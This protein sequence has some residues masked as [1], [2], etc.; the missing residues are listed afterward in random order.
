M[1]LSPLHDRLHA[2]LAGMNYR[3]IGELTET[4]AETARRYMH[5]AAPSTEFLAA[6]CVRLGING[7]WLLTGRGPMKA[8]DVRGR[9]L[10]EATAHELLHAMANTI[11]MLIARVDRLEVFVHTLE[12]RLRVSGEAV[13]P[14]LDEAYP[15]TNGA[16]HDAATARRED[17]PEDHLA[18]RTFE[19]QAGRHEN[20]SAFGRQAER[21]A[22]VV[23]PH[24]RDVAAALTQRPRE[25]DR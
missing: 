11:E 19:D 4:N 5:G 23:S 7:E 13:A 21:P 2:V 14:A 20:G 10:D 1:D 22:V 24:A 15:T 6:V 12:T 8:K 18:G 3:R 17:H 16:S 25:G 9:A